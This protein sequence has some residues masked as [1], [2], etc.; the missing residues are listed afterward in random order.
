CFQTCHRR[1]R[2]D[3]HQCPT[4]REDLSSLTGTKH[5]ANLHRWHV[6]AK[7]KAFAI[8]EFARKTRTVLIGTESTR[9]KL[10]DHPSAPDN[11]GRACINPPNMQ[12]WPY[13][14]DAAN[15]L[16]ESLQVRLIR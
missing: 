2:L 15:T 7:F 8:L 9:N 14:D 4:C 16:R 3:Q 11:S 12:E 5:G 1:R 6:E 10:F 13:T